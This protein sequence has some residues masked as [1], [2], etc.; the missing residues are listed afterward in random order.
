[1]HLNETCN[2]V[3]IDKHFSDSF[4]VQTGLKEGDGLSH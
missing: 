2:K 4:S 1:M 3:F